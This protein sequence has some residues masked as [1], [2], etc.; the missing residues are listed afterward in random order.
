MSTRRI[1][2]KYL[3]VAIH[4]HNGLKKG[5]LSKLVCMFPPSYGIKMKENERG[6]KFIVLNQFLLY[7]V[8]VILEGDHSTI[9][10]YAELLVV[11]P[12]ILVWNMK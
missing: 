3:S 10:K 9:K 2:L 5:H 1:I 7:T 6:L 12:C 4:F 8:G 11:L